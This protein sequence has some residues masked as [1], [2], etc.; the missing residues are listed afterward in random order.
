AGSVSVLACT[1]QK[2]G[3]SL[4]R[5]ARE[6]LLWHYLLFHTASTH[7]KKVEAWR[8]ASSESGSVMH[9]DIELW[10]KDYK[11]MPRFVRVESSM[12][13]RQ[14]CTGPPHGT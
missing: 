6:V 14:R 10:I 4:Q 13:D 2:A 8:E 11:D 3:S 7:V 12:S 5:L 9:E 1:E